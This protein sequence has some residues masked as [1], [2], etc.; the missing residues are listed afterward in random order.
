MSNR[1]RPH[2]RSAMTTRAPSH[3]Q[4]AAM[5]DDVRQLVEPFTIP[6]R[7]RARGGR[8]TWT[9]IHHPPLLDQLRVAAQPGATARGPAHHRIP[10]SRPPANLD[11]INAEAGIWVAVTN[12]HTRLHLPSPPT[13]VDWLTFTLRQLVG[14]AP[15]LAPSIADQLADD[16]HRWWRTAAV[17]AGWNPHDLAAS[18]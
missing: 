1:D 3:D 2:G 7:Q 4:L 14:A 9:A 10:D 16:V 15:H 6:V 8:T 13:D 18:R 17:Q 12:W 5:A 11:A